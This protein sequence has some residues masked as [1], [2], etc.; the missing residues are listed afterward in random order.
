MQGIL[1]ALV[2]P[3]V[4]PGLGAQGAVGKVELLISHGQPN[5]IH[6]GA[7]RCPI[8]MGSQRPINEGGYVRLG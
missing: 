8:R 1:T 5:N 4:G 7:N 3:P 6:Q 2:I